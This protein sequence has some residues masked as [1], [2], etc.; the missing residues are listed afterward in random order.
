LFKNRALSLNNSIGS[1][2]IELHTVESTNNYA[3]GLVHEGV[4]HHGTAVFAHE[5][6]KG[7]GQRDKEWISEGGKNVALSIV[8][9]PKT[10]ALSESFLLSMC[11]AVATQQFVIKSLGNE[12]T[13]KC[14][15]DIYWRDRKAGGILIENVLQGSNWKF[16][17]AGIGLNINQAWF[18]D[19]ET[20]AVSFKQVTGLELDP[21]EL[22]KELCKAI[23]GS[24]KLLSHQPQKLIEEYKSA[25]FKRDEIVR[26]KKGSRVFNAIVKDVTTQGQLVVQHSIEERFDAGDVEWVIS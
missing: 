16:A 17:I 9:E 11:V 6:T 25:L 18:P 2:F 7:K 15:N 1:P 12:V 22:A 19:L 13:I 3:M 24:F 8:I 26:F 4:A 20:K 14:P 10:L 23:D 5:Q 21:L